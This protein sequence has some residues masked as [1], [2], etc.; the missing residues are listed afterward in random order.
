MINPKLLPARRSLQSALRLMI[1]LTLL[2]GLLPA[3]SLGRAATG[4]ERAIADTLGLEV[5][6][7]VTQKAKLTA[8]DAAAS[9]QFG[10][11]VAVDGT[12]A[13]VG[14]SG[15]DSSQ[16]A[17][18]VFYRDQGGDDNWGQLTKLTA[19]DGAAG[20]N[21]GNS[22]ALDG[23]TAIVGAWGDNTETGAAYVFYRNQ[24]GADAWGQVTKITAT[25]AATSDDFGWAV[26]LNGDTALI[27]AKYGDDDGGPVDDTGAAYVFY[28]NQ[29]GA[30]AWG[31][32]TKLVAGSG[33][34]D[35]TFGAAVA[36]NGDTALVGAWSENT[37]QGAAYVFYRDQGGADAWGQVVRVTASDGSAGNAYGYALDVKGDL[38]LIGAWNYNNARGSVYILDRNLGGA[39]NWGEVT[40]LTADT[41]EANDKF[42]YSVVLSNETAVIGAWGDNNANGN[43]AGSVYLFGRNLGGVDNWGQAGMALANDGVD[44]DA[45]GFSVAASGNLILTGAN[46]DDGVGVDSGSAYLLAPSGIDSIGTYSQLNARY[47][48]RNTNDEGPDDYNFI[49]ASNITNGIPITGDWDGDGID[50]IG[51]FDPEKGKFRLRNS[52]DEGASDIILENAFFIGA[53]P[54]VGDWNG[55]GVDTYGVYLA[56]KVYLRNTNDVG[57]PDIKF[58]MDG[59]GFILIVGDWDGDGIDTVSLFDQTRGNFLLRN[60]NSAGPPDIIISSNL[61]IGATPITG[62]WDGDGVDTIGIYVAG[63]VYLRNTNDKGRP[64]LR[65]DYGSGAVIPITG[66]W[67]GA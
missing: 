1:V 51:V 45:F 2:I 13:I 17:V 47:R 9:D 22:V 59:K 40:K 49:F 36:I 48:L 28:R 56:G 43:G 60:S 7:M 58:K 23:D 11:S 29:G 18:Y 19:S 15:D 39:D 16:G 6:G 24:G 4:L 10:A 64:D 12:T 41:P 33:A 26:S 32:I 53:T 27:G 50:T 55:D 37:F 38:A 35:D 21:F 25:D 44:G 54:L 42:G 65:F 61:L 67:D 14:A 62:D 20:D 5:A 34:A 3:P 57:W 52:N 30:D 66:D 31:Q 63:K 46:K 8:S